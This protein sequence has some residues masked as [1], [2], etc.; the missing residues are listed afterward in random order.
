MDG[1]I[2]LITLT[3][4]GKAHQREV[5]PETP[6]LY[7]LRGERALK[8]AK[9]GCGLGEAAQGPTAAAIANAIAAATGTRLRDIP[10]TLP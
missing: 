5:D 10:L 6:L 7:V 8:G 2:S 9:F 1:R 3:V 4:N